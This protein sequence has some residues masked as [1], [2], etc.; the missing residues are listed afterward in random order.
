VFN[1]NAIEISFG[2][3]FRLGKTIVKF[4]PE[5]EVVQPVEADRKNERSSQWIPIP[6]TD[7]EL[8]GN[9]DYVNL[10]GRDVCSSASTASTRAA[11]SPKRSEGRHSRCS[12]AE[13]HRYQ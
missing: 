5:E 3:E 7:R 11:T 9:R 1:V 8:T 6:R 13:G 12:H 10:A 2:A 4:L